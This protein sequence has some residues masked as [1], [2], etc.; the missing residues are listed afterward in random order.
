MEMMNRMS[1]KPN[2]QTKIFDN[3]VTTKWKAEFLA[4]PDMDVSEKM[5]D[6]VSHSVS[7][8]CLRPDHGVECGG[9]PVQSAHA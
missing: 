4:T 6:A 5:V 9:A 2:W 7:L 1:D 3:N 8:W